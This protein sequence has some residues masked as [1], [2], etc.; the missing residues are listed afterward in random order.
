MLGLLWQRRFWGERSFSQYGVFSVIWKGVGA[1]GA[2]FT[3]A[4]LNKITGIARS[5]VTNNLLKMW[6]FGMVG[7][8]RRL[9]ARYFINRDYEQHYREYETKIG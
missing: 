1:P 2:S 3:V 6:V 9:P 7:K 5:T 8:E 4:E